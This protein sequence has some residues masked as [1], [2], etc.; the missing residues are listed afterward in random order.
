MNSFVG[1]LAMHN[2]HTQQWLLPA[3]LV[4][5]P[6]TNSLNRLSSF[7]TTYHKLN[8]HFITLFNLAAILLDE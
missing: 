1:V 3:T 5:A 4:P 8:V 7:F 6:G 2:S